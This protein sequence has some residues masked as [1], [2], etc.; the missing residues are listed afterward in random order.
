MRGVGWGGVTRVRACVGAGPCSTRRTPRGG[1]GKQPAAGSR[2]P[3]LAP[4]PRPRPP[5]GAHTPAPPRRPPRAAGQRN[6]AERRVPRASARVPPHTHRAAASS[7]LPP[8]GRRTLYFCLS[9]VR[10]ERDLVLFFGCGVASGARVGAKGRDCQPGRGAAAR[11]AAARGVGARQ[12]EGAL[13][14]QAGLAAGAA[15]AHHGC[16][17]G[18]RTPARLRPAPERVHAVAP[19]RAAAPPQRPAARPLPPRA[20]PG[21]THRY[22]RRAARS[23]P[24]PAAMGAGSHAAAHTQQRGVPAPTR[25]RRGGRPRGRAGRHTHCASHLVRKSRCTPRGKEKA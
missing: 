23:T 4:P 17:R 2:Q 1:R 19:P 24:S 21:G 9:V 16:A 11:G 3:P 25:R 22:A 7:S 20:P 12:R 6:Q 15:N 14:R 5:L 10:L 18:A 13:A 8:R